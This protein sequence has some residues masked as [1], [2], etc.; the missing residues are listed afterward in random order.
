MDEKKLIKKFI[1]ISK[2][3]WIKGVN[4]TTNSVGLTFESLLNKESDSMY[5]P[6][7]GSIE[8]KCS[9]RFSRYPISLFSLSFDGPRLYEMNRLVQTY[10][11]KDII[12]KDKFQRK[13]AYM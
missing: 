12:Y 3:R 11:K 5:F 2:K 1:E 8:I 13:E 7:Y 10:G 4:N 9:Q 6:D